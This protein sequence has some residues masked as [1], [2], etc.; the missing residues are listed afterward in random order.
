MSGHFLPFYPL[1]KP[2]KSKFWKMKKFAGGIIILQMCTINDSQMMYGYDDI[3]CNGQNFLSF[4]IV[5]CH[6]TPLTTRKI[7]KKKKMKNTPEDI[8]I[9]QMCTIDDNHIMYG[10]WDIECDGQ[11]FFVILDCFC[12]F[13]P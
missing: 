6:F 11:F 2:Q 8:I 4:W 5:F 3:E 1:K 13:I 10:S 7:K 12:T 9:L